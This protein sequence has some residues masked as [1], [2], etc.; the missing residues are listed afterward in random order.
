MSWEF[1]CLN[2]SLVLWQV[3]PKLT[4]SQK[5][6]MRFIIKHILLGSAALQ[7]NNCWKITQLTPEEDHVW[8][9]ITLCIQLCKLWMTGSPFEMFGF[10]LLIKALTADYLFIL[11]LWFDRLH[12]E[13][14]KDLSDL[15]KF[16][17]NSFLALAQTSINISWLS[18]CLLGVHVQQFIML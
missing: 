4:M 2:R 9:A 11:K 18:K 16:Y 3:H 6:A 7:T 5:T 10:K 17:L 15:L 12:A 1:S 8:I 13:A 14:P